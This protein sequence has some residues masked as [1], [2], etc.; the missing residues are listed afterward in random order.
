MSVS[1][2]EKTVWF[3]DTDEDDHATIYKNDKYRWLRVVPA[4]DSEKRIAITFD[5]GVTMQCDLH[6]GNS[7][8]TAVLVAPVGMMTLGMHSRMY[9]FVYRLQRFVRDTYGL[10]Y[11]D[12]VTTL[13]EV[14]SSLVYKSEELAYLA[15]GQSF[16]MELRNASSQWLLTALYEQESR[17]P[18]YN[19]GKVRSVVSA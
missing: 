13:Q 3:F 1:L 10:R 11:E 17:L 8:N 15:Q 18:T 14:Q 9:G 4:H 2:S 12:Y 16:S 7:P 19:L 6:I 5:T